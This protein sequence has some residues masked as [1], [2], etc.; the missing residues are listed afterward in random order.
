VMPSTDGAGL[1]KRPFRLR[2]RCR[3]TYAACIFSPGRTDEISKCWQK[4]VIDPLHLACKPVPRL[5]VLNFPVPVYSA[6]AHRLHSR[7]RAHS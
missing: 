3:R 2:C 4:M 7:Y 6:A 1:R 5:V